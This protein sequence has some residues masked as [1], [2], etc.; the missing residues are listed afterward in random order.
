MAPHLLAH[1]LV[2]Y[3]ASGTFGGFLTENIFHKSVGIWTCDT[4]FESGGRRECGS[5]LGGTGSCRGV[6][7]FGREHWRW[8]G[9]PAGRGPFLCDFA[10]SNGPHT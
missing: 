10:V 5:A 6:E 9:R 4:P 3:L 1:I 2:K 7:I 8:G